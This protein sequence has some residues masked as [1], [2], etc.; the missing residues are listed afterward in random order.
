MSG[1]RLSLAILCAVYFTILASCD[2]SAE[3]HPKTEIVP[4]LG[5]TDL[6]SFRL[7]FHQTEQPPYRGA[8]R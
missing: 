7:L 4:Q 8:D 1:S 2:V 6:M 5:D 3:G